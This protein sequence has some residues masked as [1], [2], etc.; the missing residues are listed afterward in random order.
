MLQN[1]KLLVNFEDL[2]SIRPLGDM[3][4]IRVE[5]YILEA[6]SHDLMPILNDALYYDFIK[7]FDNEDPTYDKYRDLLN[8]KEYTYNGNVVEF[9]GLVEMISFFALARLIPAN[10]NHFTRFGAVKKKQENSD[11]LS[12]DDVQ[13]VVR[14]LRS[15]AIF[16]VQYVKQFLIANISQ[17]PLYNSLPPK[18]I[19]KTGVKFFD[20]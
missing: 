7:N 18:S 17:Y 13:M 16:H 8:G 20:V 11:A 4:P 15:N 1:K 10:V 19:N 12:A 3:D 2:K 14:E 6:Q 5:P 9:T